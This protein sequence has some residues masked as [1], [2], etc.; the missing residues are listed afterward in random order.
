MNHIALLGDSI[1]DNAAYVAG[2]PDVVRQVRELL[3]SGWRATLN[4][5]D[6]AVIADVPQQ[7]QRLPAD[8]SHLVVSVGGNDALGEASLLDQ[9][10]GSVADALE[11]ITQIRERFRSGYA[12]MLDQV[13]NR[14]LP[15][16][17]CTI[18]EPRFPEPMRRRLA[19]TALTRSTTRLRGRLLPA[20]S[21]VST[22]ASSAMTIGTSPI[23]SNRRSMAERRSPGRYLA[24]PTPIRRNDLGWSRGSPCYI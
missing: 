22:S 19:A 15:I 11:L 2:E 10:V 16:A 9:K 8:A 20:R 12:R 18:Y 21:T 14:R 4:A 13:L 24:S 17:V 23:P 6:G 5:V 1:F 7:L 3:P